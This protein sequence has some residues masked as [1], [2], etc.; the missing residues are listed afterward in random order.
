VPGRQDGPGPTAGLGLPGGRFD[1]LACQLDGI[2]HAGARVNFSY[3]YD[4]LRAA[5]VGGTEEILRLA[6]RGPVTGVQYVSTYGIWGIPPGGLTVITE[7]EDIGRAG[8]LVTGYVQTKW[9]AEY[10]VTLA[11]DR[12]V[13]IDVYRPGRVLGD[14]RTGAC[15]TTHFTTRVI[16][17]CIELG[18]APELDLDVEMTPVDY[19]ASALVRASLAPRPFGANLHLVNGAKMPF[20]ELVGQLSS[21]GWEVP[22]VPVGQWWQ[23]LRD[24]YAIRPNELHPVMD[25]VEEFIV[26]G[27]EAISYDVTHAVEALQGTGVACPRLD[28]DLLDTYLRWMVRTGYLPDPEPGR[29]R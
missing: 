29:A 26:G 27:E 5:N 7:D 12:G 13:P 14:S 10:L 17:G 3:T 4:Q 19:V 1:E 16:K 15:L 20:A 11:R 22:V 9:A 28:A 21:H 6:C 2:Y 8:R 18:M 24:S 25:V 23:A